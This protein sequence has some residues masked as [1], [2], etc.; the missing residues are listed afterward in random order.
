MEIEQQHMGYIAS[1]WPS[2]AA[3]A[4]RG[5][6]AEGRGAVVIDRETVRQGGAPDDRFLMVYYLSEATLR[7]RGVW[8]Q[9]PVCEAIDAYTPETEAVILFRLPGGEQP[10]YKINIEELTPPQAAA[11]RG[12]GHVG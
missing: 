7:E 2:L 5:F 8:S 6:Q 10:A 9:H 4:W 12:D 1:N 11:M 3:M